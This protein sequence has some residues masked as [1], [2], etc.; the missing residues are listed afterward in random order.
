MKT[1]IGMFAVLL[2]LA[3]PGMAQV[4]LGINFYGGGG[5][6]FPS[7]DLNDIVKNGYHFTLGAGYSPV[8]MLETVGRYARH[9]LPLDNDSDEDFTMTEYGVDVRA[10]IVAPGAS[11]KPYVLIGAGFAKY[12][13]PQAAFDDLSGAMDAALG[14]LE[15]KTKFFY[16]F[17]AGIKVSAVTKLN[18][19]SGGTL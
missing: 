18:F 3:G 7:G 1:T 5:L 6:T 11:A 2:L 17:G 19:F 15:P 9:A 4:G 14:G 8:P 16:C 12:D 10:R 13:F